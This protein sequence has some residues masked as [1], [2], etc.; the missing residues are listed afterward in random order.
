MVISC[1]CEIARITGPQVFQ[2][3]GRE[4]FLLPDLEGGPWERLAMT[5]HFLGEGFSLKGPRDGNKVLQ[6]ETEPIGWFLRLV[7]EFPGVFITHHEFL[8]FLQL[9]ALENPSNPPCWGQVMLL[10]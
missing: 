9:P 1:N 7:P 3:S 5:F 6:K 4:C 8:G 10:W 2:V